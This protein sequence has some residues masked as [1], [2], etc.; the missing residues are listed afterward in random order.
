MTIGT[1]KRVPTQIADE[2]NTDQPQTNQAST[3]HKKDIDVVAFKSKT[4]RA[5]QVSD[6]RGRKPKIIS[7]Q[8]A[9][10]FDRSTSSAVFNPDISRNCAAIEKV[11]QVTQ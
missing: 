2:V 1:L 4:M 9:E 6:T 5:K 11:T 8:T 10:A 7:Q 3:V